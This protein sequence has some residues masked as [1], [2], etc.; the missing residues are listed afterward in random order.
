[1]LHIISI[2]NFL[3]GFRLAFDMNYVHE[4][5]ALWFDG[6][7]IFYEVPGSCLL[8][9]DVEFNSKSRKRQKVGTVVSNFEAINHFL[10]TYTTEDVNVETDTDII[11]FTE[12]SNESPTKHAEALWNKLLRVIQ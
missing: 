5:A 10:D 9:T 3:F 1:M 2:L 7:H 4:W 8:D 6:S 11:H 12:L